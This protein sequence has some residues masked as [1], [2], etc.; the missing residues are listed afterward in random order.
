MKRNKLTSYSILISDAER[1]KIEGILRDEGWDLGAAPH[2][3]WKARKDKVSLAAYNSGKLTVQGSGTE[4]FVLFTLEPRV[5][6]KPLLG[7]P[8]CPCGENPEASVGFPHAGIDESGKGDFFGP[9]VIAAVFADEAM[10]QSLVKGGVKD[11]KLIKNDTAIRRIAEN[12]RLTVR[13]KFSVVSIGPEAY[14][15]L[16]EKIGNLNRLL[17][18]GHARALENLL[19]K[20]PECHTALADQFGNELLIKKALLAK[21]RKIRLIQRTKGERDVAVAAASILARDEFVRKIEQLGSAEG[22]SLPKGAGPNVEQKVREIA[23]EPGGIQK[24]ARIGKIHFKTLSKILH[25]S[26]RQL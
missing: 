22:T 11:S 12:I 10:A 17:A 1:R 26:D 24:L 18:W 8:G 6:G 2:T 16:Y 23:A 25:P 14:N 21:G 9:L 15:R 4:D 20:I 5:T 7:Q 3:F 19:E 13:G